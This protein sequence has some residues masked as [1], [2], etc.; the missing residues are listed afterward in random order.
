M[1]QFESPQLLWLLLLIPL[2]ILWYWFRGFRNEYH[3]IYGR[4]KALRGIRPGF[5]VIVRYLLLPM[6]LGGIALLIIAIARPQ[7]VNTERV[8]NSEG[9]DIM[10]ALDLS[11]S[12]R[13]QDLIPNRLAAAKDVAADFVKG[14][15]ADRIGVVVYAGEAFTQCPLTLD[16]D[17]I[18]RVLGSLVFDETNPGTAIGMGIATSLNRLRDSQAKSKVIILLTDGQNNSGDIDP[19]TAAD[20]A[21]SL[22]VKIYTIGVGTRGEAPVPAIDAFGREVLI[23][24]KVDV[25]D[26]TLTKV[27]EM[28][29]GKYFRAT[30]NESLKKIY[31]EIGELEKTKVEIKNYY[32]YEEKYLPYLIAGI[33]LLL[34]EFLLSKTRART[35]ITELGMELK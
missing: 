29:G 5:W 35:S 8:I 25:D 30:D 32:Q 10:L 3:F 14:R 12:M 13:A 33:I 23:R 26:E 6:K 27:A 28:T 4:Q 15:V 31:A 21:I 34:L 20:L 1:L 18:R 9:I 22:G 16:Y 17:M 7:E 2:W 19:L 11:G 24:Q